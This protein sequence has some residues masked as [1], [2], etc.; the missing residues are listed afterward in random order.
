MVQTTFK[1]WGSHSE[2]FMFKK[3]HI[4]ANTNENVRTGNNSTVQFLIAS[5]AQLNGLTK[6][7]YWKLRTMF[8]FIGLYIS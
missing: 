5:R 4:L 7:K 2:Q 8:V 6:T 3:K 1:E